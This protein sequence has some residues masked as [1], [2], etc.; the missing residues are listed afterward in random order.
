MRRV[1]LLGLLLVAGCAKDSVYDS[2]L[3]DQDGDG[4]PVGEDCDD[5]NAAL[6]PDATETCDGQDNNCDG[7]VDEDLGTTW[8]PD[9]DGDGYGQEEGGVV[10]CDPPSGHITIGGDCDDENAEIHPVALEVCDGLDNDC[11]GEADDLDSSE[12]QIWYLDA[13]GDGYGDSDNVVVDCRMPE[14]HVPVGGDCDDND[15]SSYPGAE[16]LCDGIDND[17]DGDV[18][19]D[20]IWYLDE[21]ADGFGAESNQ[22]V[23]CEEIEGRTS[24]GGDCDD[25]TAEVNPDARE[26]CDHQDN[27]C[28]GTIDEDYFELDF[29][30]PVDPTIFSINGDAIKTSD[31]DGGFLL[32]T[33]AVET[34][35]GSGFFVDTIPANLWRVSFT[36]EVGGGTGADGLTLAFL[37]ES[38]STLV[39][40]SGG[41]LGL[42]NLQGYAFEWDT[43]YNSDIGDPTSHHC[44]LVYASDLNHLATAACDFVDVGSLAV[45]VSFDEGDYEVSLEGATVLSG[46][47]NDTFEGEVMI[48]FTAATGGLTNRHIVDDISVGCPP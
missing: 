7:Q 6:H 26:V 5:D 34:Q 31:S 45:V 30:S 9:E 22:V 40:G 1:V 48:G 20:V 3:E 15:D 14:G 28:D 47:L 21:D 19:P 2:S 16:E 11:N 35:V 17:C 18:D 44:G 10:A 12:F 41:G 42:R 33:D 32:L 38:D 24:V 36:L 13:D 27:N 4:F 8:Y 43:Y 46:T 29:E 23:S 39:G 37:D 25:S